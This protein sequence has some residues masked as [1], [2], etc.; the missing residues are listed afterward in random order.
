MVIR[1]NKNQIFKVF[2]SI[3][4]LLVLQ[5]DYFFSDVFAIE[6]I[7]WV[8][9]SFLLI[10]NTLVHLGLKQLKKDWIANIVNTAVFFVSVFN[11]FILAIILF[12][13]GFT[14]Q[15]TPFIWYIAV[16]FEIALFVTAIIDVKYR[17]SKNK[18]T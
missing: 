3:C 14:G 10:L 9:F 1:M 16:I 17:I 8:G 7:F 4:S 15:K 6:S 5:F 13:F 2:I 11:L 12:G 18:N